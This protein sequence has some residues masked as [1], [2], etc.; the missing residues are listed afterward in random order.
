MK[1]LEEILNTPAEKIQPRSQPSEYVVDTMGSHCQ[2]SDPLR[3]LP[4]PKREWKHPDSERE[5]QDE[6]ENILIEDFDLWRQVPISCI[7][8]ASGI[9]NYCRVDLLAVPKARP[10]VSIALEIKR[11]G[12]DIENAFKQSADY[13]NG[14][15]LEAPNYGKR[16]HACFL[17]P[18]GNWH[19]SKSERIEGMW[20]LV[21]QW[22]VGRA[23]IEPYDHELILAIGLVTL[24]RSK[25]GWTGHGNSRRPPG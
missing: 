8:S 23:F 2:P 16:I 10:D 15:V 4:K 14:R 7:R 3:F 22:R 11:N 24:W 18:A 13:V 20:N 5:R 6:I 1:S 17:Y 25:R 9:R 12:F 21:A 19:Y